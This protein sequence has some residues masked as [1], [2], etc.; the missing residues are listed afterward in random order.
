MFTKKD[1][2]EMSK[3]TYKHWAKKNDSIT[4]K[5]KTEALARLKDWLDKARIKKGKL[6]E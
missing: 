1:I 4:L 3:T 5:E 6:H 2:E